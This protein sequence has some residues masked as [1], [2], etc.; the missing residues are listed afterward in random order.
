MKELESRW[1]RLINR[2]ARENLVEDARSLI[3]DNLR[4]NLKVQKSFK[5]TGE[6]ISQMATYIINSNK[7]LASLAD[8]DSLVLYTELY[9]LKL[10]GNIK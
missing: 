7:A 9:I 10:L 6:S 4:R 2:K 3:R 8:R 1:S 5:L